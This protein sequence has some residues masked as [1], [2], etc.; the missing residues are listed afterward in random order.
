MQNFLSTRA[1]LILLILT[2]RAEFFLN[3]ICLDKETFLPI[4]YF[5]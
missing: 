5:F 4:L 3:T 1:I 2:G